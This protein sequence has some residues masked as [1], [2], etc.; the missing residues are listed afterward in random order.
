M[1]Y[2]YIAGRSFQTKSL[3][4]PEVCCGHPSVGKVVGLESAFTE[5][6]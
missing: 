6:L 2:Y 5:A 3:A 1:L 4:R